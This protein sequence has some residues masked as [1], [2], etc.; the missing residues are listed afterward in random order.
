MKR[1]FTCAITAMLLILVARQAGVYAVPEVSFVPPTPPDGATVVGTSVEIKAQIVEVDLANVTFNWNGTDYTIY[2]DSVVLM[3]NFDNVAADSRVD[4]GGTFV[5]D[6]TPVTIHEVQLTGLA[7]DT[8]YSYTVT[9]GGN[10]GPISTFT[11]APATDRSLRFVAYGDTRSQ[12]AEHSAVIQAIISGAPELVIH[13]GD[14]VA[15]G[16]R[17]SES[18]ARPYRWATSKMIVSPPPL[19]MRQPR[20]ITAGL[21]S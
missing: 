16:T 4:F 7:A 1:E 14:L 5:E 6:A 12:P 8:V 2:D 10:T 18:R 19:M 15:D 11:T 17:E 20:S 21:Q 9:S 13:T 3:F